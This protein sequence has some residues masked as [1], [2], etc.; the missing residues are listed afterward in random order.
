MMIGSYR[1]YIVIRFESI[2]EGIDFMSSYEY[3]SSFIVGNSIYNRYGFEIFYE[4][5]L[6][7]LSKDIRNVLI[8][9]DYFIESKICYDNNC[10]FIDKI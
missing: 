4:N 9:P 1:I 7:I 10:L 3:P 5:I 2:Q 6:E 8:N